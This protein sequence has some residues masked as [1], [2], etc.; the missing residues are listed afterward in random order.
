[1][2]RALILGVVGLTLAGAFA[3]GY[4]ASRASR[5]TAPVAAPG[6][7]DQVRS[8]LAARYYRPVPDSVLRLGSVRKIISALGDPYTAYLDP[9]SYRLV[10]Q[11]TASAYSGIGVSVLPSPQGLVIVSLRDGPAERAGVHVGDT[12]VSIGG[13]TAQ[14]LSLAH[15]MS[16]ILGPPGTAVHLRLLRGGKRLNLQVVR[17]R[18]ATPAVHARLISYAGRRWGVLQLSAFK[19]GSTVLLRREIADLRRLGAAGLVLDLRDNPGG[20]LEQAV[21][22]TSLFMD[23]GVVATLKGEHQPMQVLHA[24]PGVATHLPLVVLV[25]R[26]TASSAEIVAGALRD[27]HRATIVGERTFGK[28]LVQAVDPLDNGAALELTIARYWTPAGDDL[29]GVGL[30]PQIHAVDNPRTKQD[31]ALATALRVL[32]RPTS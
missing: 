9:R 7:V 10:R 27:N 11:E 3:I 16:A 6:V 20:L 15:A 17:A 24:L 1:M 22:V 31:E 25:D 4:R 21:D 30:E 19:T 2:R 8:A 18:I 26:Y 13:R 5:A 12:I 29:S 28:A 14:H 23:R 32:A